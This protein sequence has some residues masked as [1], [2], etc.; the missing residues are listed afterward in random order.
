MEVFRRWK[1]KRRVTSRPPQDTSRDRTPGPQSRA[2]TDSG[3]SERP[4]NAPVTEAQVTVSEDAPPTADTARTGPP[5]RVPTGPAT[6][7]RPRRREDFEIAVFCTL[8]LE[9]N[10]LYK[11]GRIGKHNV[12]VA[13]LSG[14]GKTSAASTAARIRSSYPRIRLALLVGIC[15]AVP[16]TGG[17]EILLGDVVISKAIVQYDFGR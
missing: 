17:M 10:D 14:M 1:E 4:S 7:P 8:P 9:S 11:T 6:V 5:S 3:P 2:D 13:L 15:G 12:V 16:Q